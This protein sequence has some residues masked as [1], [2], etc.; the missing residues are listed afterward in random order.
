MV[1]TKCKPCTESFSAEA[2]CNDDYSQNRRPGRQLG[3]SGAQ[4]SD[5][6]MTW[7]FAMMSLPRDMPMIRRVVT[8]SR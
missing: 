4:D 7:A 8:S 1:T 2:K 6:G 3:V 5:F